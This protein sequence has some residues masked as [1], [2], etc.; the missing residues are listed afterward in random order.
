M[1]GRFLSPYDDSHEHALSHCL[2]ACKAWDLIEREMESSLT[3]DEIM[4]IEDL[5]VPCMNALTGVSRCRHISP[6]LSP[7]TPSM[8]ERVYRYAEVLYCIRREITL[9]LRFHGMASKVSTILKS[10]LHLRPPQWHREASDTLGFYLES[11]YNIAHWTSDRAQQ[12]PL[13]GCR[14]TGQ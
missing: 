8:S 2:Y 7:R 1:Q 13:S 10:E 12:C 14:H 4:D 3:Q 11:S 5:V 9:L 6:V